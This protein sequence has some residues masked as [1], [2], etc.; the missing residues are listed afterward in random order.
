[1]LTIIGSKIC[2]Y[3]YFIYENVIVKKKHQKILTT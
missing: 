2:N 1:M 3:E